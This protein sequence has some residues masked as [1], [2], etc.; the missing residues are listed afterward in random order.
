MVDFSVE[1]D[2]M[3]LLTS[4]DGWG[5]RAWPVTLAGDG[6]TPASLD[7]V[8]A[9]RTFVLW[10]PVEDT[11]VTPVDVSVLV[12]VVGRLSTLSTLRRQRLP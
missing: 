8:G 9:L 5:P 7:P 3:G 10:F 11:E 6:T 2:S 1:A 12:P 4:L